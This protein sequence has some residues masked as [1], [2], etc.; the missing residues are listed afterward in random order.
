MA[1]GSDIK[2]RRYA[3]AVVLY[4]FSSGPGCW[5]MPPPVPAIAYAPLFLLAEWSHAF[6][7]I[8]HWYL[9][10]WISLGS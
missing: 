7:N 3:A 1:E 9:R 4:V 8:F 6:A 2:W 5:L 10:L